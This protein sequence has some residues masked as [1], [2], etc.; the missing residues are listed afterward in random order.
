[1][2][3]I[4]GEPLA[5]RHRRAVFFVLCLGQAPYYVE[6]PGFPPLTG[7]PTVSP[8]PAPLRRS[9]SPTTGGGPDAM[10]IIDARNAE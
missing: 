4:P 1:M 10:E 9:G 6:P 7:L 2:M 3:V 8:D 5:T